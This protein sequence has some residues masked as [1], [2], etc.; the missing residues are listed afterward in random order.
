MKT[1]QT[2]KIAQPPTESTSESAACISAEQMQEYL[3]GWSDEDDLQRIEIHVSQCAECEQTMRN[4]EVGPDTLMQSLQSTAKG[5]TFKPDNQRDAVSVPPKA[6]HSEDDAATAAALEKARRLMDVPL[7]SAAAKA[8]AAWQPADRDFGGYELTQPLGR[9]GMGAVYLATHRQLNKQVAI[10][11]LPLMSA[12][13]VAGRARFEREIRVVGRLNH[14]SIVAATDAGEID[15]TQF[16]VME[17]VPGLDLSRLARLTGPLSVAN[18]C[19]LMRQTALG[20]SVAHTEGVVHRDVK[21]SNLMLDETGH[22][23][24]LDF[25]LAQLSF[26]DEASADLTTVGQLMGTLDYMAPEQAEHCGAVDY[27][28]DLYALGATLFRLLCN[29]PPL[30]AA[31]NQSPLEKLR[32]LASHQ[33]PKL[34]TLCPDAPADLVALVSCL[35]ARNP[36]DRPASAAHVA[37]Q[38]APFATDC[39]LV[40]LL[41][42]AQKKSETSPELLAPLPAGFA[43]KPGFHR[44]NAAKAS[45]SGGGRKW[46]RWVAMAALPL[47]ILAGI[48]I[49]LETDKGQLVIE[50]EVD[51]VNVQIVSDG[52]P[53]S[54]LSVNHGTTATKLR[55]DRYEVTIDGATDGLTI[56]NN[57]FTLKKGETVVARIRMQPQEPSLATQQPAAEAPPSPPP[58]MSEPLYE[59]KTLS[60]WLEMLARERSPAGLK[61]A[62]DAC[63]AL[64]NAETSDRITKTILEVVP[65]LDGD[66]NLGGS[67]YS[68]SKSTDRMAEAVLRKANPGAAFYR[69]WVR[70]FEAADEDWQRRLWGYVNRGV[71][72]V[73]TM[74]P[75]VAWAE[76]RLKLLP[77]GNSSVDANTVEAADFLRGQTQKPRA[78]DDLLFAERIA[79]ILKNSPHL[80]PDW[81]LKVPLIYRN[82]KG[83][84][85]DGLDLWLTAM[86]SEMIRIAVG[87]I[88][89]P[90]SHKQLVAQACLILG[91]GAE[92]DQTQRNKVLAAVDRRLVDLS[93]APAAM[94]EIVRLDDNFRSLSLPEFKEIRLHAQGELGTYPIFPLLDVVK[95]HNGAELVPAE[96]KSLSSYTKAVLQVI[97]E[98]SDPHSSGQYGRKLSG[99]PTISLNWPEL[100]LVDDGRRGGFSRSGFSSQMQ[101]PA[102]SHVWGK[103]EPT[104]DDWLKYCILHHPV[105]QQYFADLDSRANAGSVSDV[106]KESE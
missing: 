103:H 99:R 70:E 101:G 91:H 34:N 69:I 75:V 104:T 19:E 48:L 63:K 26:W 61:S 52:K 88:D 98:R 95:E 1:T 96:L 12:D 22:I 6:Q 73:E 49:K 74:E 50:S 46:L 62:F 38:L 41:N 37:E 97:T 8:R 31:P 45:N 59:G 16:L 23:R 53:V 84:P 24:I 100:T 9:G 5:N 35:L 72:D 90:K 93:T 17:Y 87:V 105:M 66:M 4:L 55:A 2:N 64:A 71:A 78:V 33:P 77:T 14:P 21:P 102:V 81:W 13:D 89:D 54:G 44:A 10:K 86:E 39:H 82:S 51:N 25:G 80:G 76:K 18:A 79:K 40:K 57:Q 7:E 60:A 27:R 32:L 106:S 42:D 56:D 36:Q 83:H 85:T 20:L 11:L 67:G 30:A 68:G 47:I 92:L 94:R 15:G 43:G 65:G 29:R 28:A 3:S 58:T